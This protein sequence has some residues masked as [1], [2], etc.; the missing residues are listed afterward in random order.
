MREHERAVRVGHQVTGRDEPLDGLL[1]PVRTD[2][3]SGR[4][5]VVRRRPTGSRELA[6]DR[7]AHLVVARCHLD[8][9]DAP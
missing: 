6:I 8:S 5:F 7:Q 3:E 1:D 4:Q 2:V 9:S